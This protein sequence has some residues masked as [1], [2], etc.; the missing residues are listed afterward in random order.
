MMAVRDKD[1][2]KNKRYR[3]KNDYNKKRQARRKKALK[4]IIFIVMLSS[5]LVLFCMSPLFDISQI[6]VEGAEHCKEENIINASGI[7]IGQN[8]FR[9][10]GGNFRNFIFLRYGQAELNILNSFPY[11]KDAVVRYILPNKVL[12][13]IEEREPYALVP[14]IGAFLLIDREGY[15][16]EV[17][18]E[19]EKFDMPYVKGL[20]FNNYEIGKALQITNK[21]NFNKLIILIDALTEEEKNDNFKLM[22]YIDTID[23]GDVNNIY[24]YIDSRLIVNYGDLQDINYR[25]K[26]LK[27]IF[28]KSLTKEDR[29]LIDFTVGDNPVFIPEN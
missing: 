9:Y 12:I 6:Q 15:V 21:A 27:N 29:G 26:I 3:N 10:I 5:I 14:Y 28:H 4:I 18:G 2:E 13:S 20:R 11:I 8:G 24:L 23:V 22:N 25:I 1:M 19:K 7:S 17:T 16:L